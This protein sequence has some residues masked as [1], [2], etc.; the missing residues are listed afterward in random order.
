VVKIL[1]EVGIVPTNSSKW[2]YVQKP[3]GTDPKI[4]G[5]FA[6]QLT[7]LQRSFAPP[8]LTPIQ[9]KKSLRQRRKIDP[10]TERGD[11]LIRQDLRKLHRV[12]KDRHRGP[13][14]FS[15]PN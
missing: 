4:L 2:F 11:F 3:V 1:K 15:V 5:N 6:V 14:F 8:P 9:S 13:G 12:E 7:K 10:K